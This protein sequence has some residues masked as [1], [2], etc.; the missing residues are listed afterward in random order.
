[1]L[2]GIWLITLT[3]QQITKNLQQGISKEIYL[4]SIRVLV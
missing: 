1:M 2:A 3:K 4:N